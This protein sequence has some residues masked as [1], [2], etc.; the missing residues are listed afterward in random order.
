M[1]RKNLYLLLAIVG[2]IAPAVAIAP[3][4]LENGVIPHNIIM[5]MF[6]SPVGALAGFNL[7]ISCAV[8]VVLVHTE[9]RELGIK[10]WMPVVAM[11]LFGVSSGLPLYLYLRE[12]A[13]VK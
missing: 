13:Q 12:G 10:T 6:S 11:S 7:L 8:L 5:A 3:F 1:N 2:S 9:G 4:L